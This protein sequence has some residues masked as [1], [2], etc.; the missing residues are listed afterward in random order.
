[1]SI[2]KHIQNILDIRKVLILEWDPIGIFTNCDFEYDYDSYDEYDS[3][4]VEI[5]EIIDN[6]G[7]VLDL[8]RYLENVESYMGVEKTSEN[9]LIKIAQKI[10]NIIK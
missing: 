7:T 3:Y 9:I 5:I 6:G 8:C 1:M 10:F 4:L 2:K